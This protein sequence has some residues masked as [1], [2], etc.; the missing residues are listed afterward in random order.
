MN[1][2]NFINK[3]VEA[4]RPQATHWNCENE[5]EKHLKLQ[6]QS[7]KLAERSTRLSVAPAQVPAASDEIDEGAQWLDTCMYKSEL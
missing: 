2:Y 4:T 6:K 3:I 1:G 7:T 5:N